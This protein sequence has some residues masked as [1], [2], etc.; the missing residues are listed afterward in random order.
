M[1]FSYS[2]VPAPECQYDMEQGYGFAAAT[3]GSKNEDLKDSWPGEYFSPAVPTLLMDVPNGNYTVTLEIGSADSSAV[4]T[5]RE[6]L[7]RI[8]L[9]E[10][11]TGPG[12]ITTRTF[13]VHVE[14]GTLKLAFGGAAP[15]VQKVMASRVSTI[16]TLFLAGDST[17]TDQASGQFPY[18]GWG[19]MIGLYLGEGIA[20]ANHARSGRSARTFIQESRLLRIAKRLRKGDFLLIQFAHNDEKET[21]EGSGPFTTYQQYLKQYIDLARSAGAYPVLVAPMHRRFFAEDGAIRNTHGDYIE[22]MRQL[23]VREAVPFVDLASLSKTYFEELG[24]ARSRQVFLWAEPG[25]YANLPE[26]AADNTHFSE[27]GAIEIARL[28]AIGIQQAEADK[29]AQHLISNI[30]GSLI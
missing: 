19:Q 6:G 10:V 20:I 5:I 22:A 2:F 29:L 21:E 27:A 30:G 17:M 3:E 14:D 16:P 23:A 24:E 12:Q 7:G 26:G 28:A 13:A 4:T 18:T 15:A 1:M 8:R 11:K 9:L 25:Q